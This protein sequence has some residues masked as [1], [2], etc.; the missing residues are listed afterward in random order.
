MAADELPVAIWLGRVPGGEVEYTNAA[1]REVLGIDP[2]DTTRGA[3]VGPY[4]IYLPSGE[5]YPE[6]RMPFERVLQARATVVIEDLVIHRHDGRKVSLRVFAKPIFDADGNITHVLEAFTDKSREVEAEKLRAEGDRRL[7]RSQRLESV[8][9]L[10]AGIAHD[11]NNLLTVTKLAVSWLQPDETDEERSSA[12]EQ[13]SSVTDSAIDLIR[14]L[15]GFARPKQSLNARTAVEAAIKPVLEVATRTFHPGITLR[16]DLDSDGALVMGDTSQ[17]EQMIMNLV[18]NARDAITGA[19]EVVVRTRAR[20][21]GAAEGGPLPPGRYVVLDVL[22]TGSGIDPAIRDRVF[23][24][25][26]TT[27]TQGAIKGTGLGLATVHGIVEAHRGVVEILDNQPRGTVVRVTLPRVDDVARPAGR[28]TAREAE[29][30]ETPLPAGRRRL[31]MVVDD[32]PLVRTTTAA[33]LRALDFQVCEARD[34]ASAIELFAAHRDAISAVV[35]DMVMPGLSAGDVFVALRGLRSD[36][37]VLLVSGNALDEEAQAILDLGVAGYLPKP[38]DD[39]Q[40]VK[41]LQRV[42]AI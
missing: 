23:E 6:D 4:S 3:W 16:G 20:T 9:Q 29:P 10:V 30:I 38:Y 7:A 17:L 33:A 27:K 13:I 1:F 31:I 36:V 24:P 14:N 25:Y 18:I 8:G 19:G 5:P 39:K 42:G 15:L 21:V 40:L 37:R 28:A 35:L 12:L 41:A 11:F 32:E 2:P 26:F 22:D 34:G